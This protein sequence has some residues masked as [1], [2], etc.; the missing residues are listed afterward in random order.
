MM[1]DI[2]DDRARVEEGAG[3]DRADDGCQTEHTHLHTL[4]A[5]RS[6]QPA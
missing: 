3:G 2:V 4:L 5:K 1:V 6:K